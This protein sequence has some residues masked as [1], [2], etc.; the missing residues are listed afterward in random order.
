MEAFTRRLGMPRDEQQPTLQ[1]KRG[2][3]SSRWWSR[4]QRQN[5]R[6]MSRSNHNMTDFKIIHSLLPDYHKTPTTVDPATIKLIKNICLLNCAYT[7][8]FLLQSITCHNSSNM[9][10]TSVSLVIVCVTAEVWTAL[11]SVCYLKKGYN[12]TNTTTVLLDIYVH[13]L[14]WSSLKSSSYCYVYTC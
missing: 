10:C 3:S 13:K 5:R 9:D 4:R 2:R 11:L 14:I 8:T 6:R 12:H 1:W 7:Q